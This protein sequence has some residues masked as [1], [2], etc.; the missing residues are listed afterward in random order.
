MKNKEIALLCSMVSLIATSAYCADGPYISGNIGLAQMVDSTVDIKDAPFGSSEIDFDNGYLFAGAF[1]YKFSDARLEGEIGYQKNDYDNI[2]GAF[3]P[4]G[5]SGEASALSFMV[6][7]YY[8]FFNNSNFS[9]FLTAGLGFANIDFS[10]VTY[11]PGTIPPLNL[12]DSDTVLAWQFG[13][14]VGYAFTEQLTLDFKYRYFDTDKSDFEMAKTEFASHN[15][16]LGARFN[17]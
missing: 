15:F 16:I 3:G 8:D 5:I 2:K 14:G 10:D 12:D 4:D 6:N 11:T 9:F 17:F 7:G 1:G 13:A